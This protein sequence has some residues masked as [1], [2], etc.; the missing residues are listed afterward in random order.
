[1]PPAGMGTCIVHAGIACTP[2][3]AHSRQA[4]GVGWPSADSFHAHEGS[5]R[6][7]GGGTQG[8]RA[9]SKPGIVLYACT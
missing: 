5:G 3:Q 4:M 2:P 8:G 9:R 6:V 1:M 7:T